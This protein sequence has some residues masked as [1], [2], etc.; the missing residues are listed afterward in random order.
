M[1]THDHFYELMIQIKMVRQLMI[2]TGTAKGLGH[3]ETIKHSQH[4]D[5]LMNQFQSN[6]FQLKSKC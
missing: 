5:K 1:D 3:I 6:Q 2:S 4:L